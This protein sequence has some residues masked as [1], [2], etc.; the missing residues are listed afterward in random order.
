MAPGLV[1]PLERD[2]D[3]HGRR[4]L[5][6]DRRT[7]LRLAPRPHD[8]L[9][10]RLPALLEAPPHRH[11]GDQRLVRP[12]AVAGPARAARLRG[13]RRGRAPARLGDAGRHDVEADARHDVL[14]RVRTLP[15]RLPGVGDGEGPVAEA[16]DHG[17]SRSPVRRGSGGARRRRADR[18]RAGCGDR[19]GR[20]GLRDLRRVRP[21]VPGLDR[22]RRPHRR[23]AT[24]PRDGGVALP[25]RGGDDAPRRRP[26]VE[27]LGQAAVGAR[28][29][30]R[31]PRRPRARAGRSRAGGPL[32]GRL[33]GVVRRARARQCARHRDAPPPRGPRRRDPRAA[34]VVHGRPRPQDGRRVHLPGAGAAERRDARG[35]R[36][37]ADRHELSALLQHARQRVHGLRRYLRGRPSHRAAGGAPR[38]RTTRGSRGHRRDH[39]PRLLLPRPSQRRRRGAARD[40]LAH[41]TA[42]RDGPSREADLLLRC[43]RCAHV[44]GG[45]RLRHQRGARA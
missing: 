45:A 36:R 9:V 34:R 40:R 3:C 22:A 26:L 5:A 43:R 29:L 13:R 44:D 21:R 1:S 19:R 11:G 23:P 15:G 4:R 42:A 10:P 12:H 39:V 33:R 6:R 8:P 14:H 37:H 31:R 25:R 24:P 28:R 27:P 7:G 30:G 20:V 17:S 16:P 32:L 2:R 41:R 35:G 38:R 18:A